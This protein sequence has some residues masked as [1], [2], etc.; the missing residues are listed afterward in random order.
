MM[1]LPDTFAKL[2]QNDKPIPRMADAADR[3]TLAGIFAD[4]RQYFKQSAR[5]ELKSGHL[6]S[7][8][9]DLAALAG[10][11][12]LYR[13]FQKKPFRIYRDEKGNLGLETL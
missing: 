4:T 8:F 6:L 9:A 5:I 12:L 10:T 7:C 13:Q 1:A 2:A 3:A 11:K